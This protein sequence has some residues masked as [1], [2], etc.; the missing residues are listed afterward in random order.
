MQ[1]VMK[2]AI[3]QVMEKMGISE[4]ERNISFD[5]VLPKSDKELLE[6]IQIARSEKILSQL[7][8]IQYYHKI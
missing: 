4:N 3:L 7:E 1:G 8:A 2:Q 6:E 5:Q